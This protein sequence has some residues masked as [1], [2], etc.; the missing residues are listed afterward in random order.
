[1][2]AST[3]V[4]GSDDSGVSKISIE[5]GASHCSTLLA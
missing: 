2:F 1:V 3:T 5:H 4:P